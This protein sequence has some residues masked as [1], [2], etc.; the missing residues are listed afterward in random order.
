MIKRKMPQ[1]VQAFVDRHGK[2]RPLLSSAPAF[3]CR[4]TRHAILDRVHGRFT[5]GGP[6]RLW[7][8]GQRSPTTVIGAQRI[9]PGTFAALIASY[10]SALSEFLSSS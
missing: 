1:Y 8:Q 9:R 6:G 2:P 10:Y 4:S 7:E 5:R 3:R